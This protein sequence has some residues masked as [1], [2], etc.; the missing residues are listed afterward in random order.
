MISNQHDEILNYDAST[1][2]KLLANR[3][4]TSVELMKAT[5]DRIDAVNPELNAII[6]LRNRKELLQ[7]AQQC[8]ALSPHNRK[9]WLHGIPIAI[10]DLSNVAGIR[11]TIGGSPFFEHYT[12]RRSDPFVQKLLDAGAIVIGKTNT[13]ESGL[14]SH[15][16]NTMHG[17][18]RNPYDRNRSAGGSSGGAAVAVSTRMLCIADGSDMMGSLRNPAGWDNLYSIRPTAGIVETNVVAAAA[19]AIPTLEYPI[20]T[21]GPMA[22]TPKDLA[23]LLETMV[24]NINNFSNPFCDNNAT[25]SCHEKRTTMNSP[26]RILWLGNWNGAYEFEDGILEMCYDSLNKHFPSDNV[27]IHDMSSQPIFPAEDLWKSWTTI[28]SVFV[29]SL[30]IAIHGEK[31]L[32]HSK[33]TSQMR[34]ELLWEIQRGM[35]FQEHEIQHALNVA[36]DWS[37]TLERIFRDYDAFALPSAQVWPFPVDWPYPQQ[38]NDKTMDT[39]HRWMEVVVPVSLGGLP[40]VTLPAGFQED[41]GLPMGI[42]LA[43]RRGSDSFLLE[44]ADLYHQSTD[45]PSK[46]PPKC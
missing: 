12:P 8:D 18:T 16:F 41:S 19:A 25:G 9:G 22:R 42:Q 14:G 36:K 33:Y 15:T 32:L 13:P 45:W 35:A 27:T 29:S 11:T 38:I 6:L 39:Y 34:K 24:G 31:K 10:K 46:R 1:L 28:R 3:Q 37:V 17:I 21:V 30:E 2:S 26:I 4:V 7:E 5:L 43:G 20:S 40:C 23:L 44:L